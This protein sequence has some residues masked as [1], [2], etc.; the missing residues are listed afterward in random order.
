[1]EIE[2]V[3]GAVKGQLNL[4]TSQQVMWDNAVAQTKAAHEAG[5]RQHAEGP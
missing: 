2:H 1:M 3:L 5:S 4:N